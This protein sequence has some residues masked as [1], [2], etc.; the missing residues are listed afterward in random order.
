[1]SRGSSGIVQRIEDLADGMGTGFGLKG[2]NR[3]YARTSA[4][5]SSYLSR[6]YGRGQC[7]PFGPPM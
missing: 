1:M 5:A 3:S 4:E 7:D 2:S 6:Q